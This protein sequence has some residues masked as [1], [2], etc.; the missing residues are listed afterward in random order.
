LRKKWE[1]RG[2]VLPWKFTSR[3]ENKS[4]RG[5]SLLGTGFREGEILCAILTRHSRKK[6]RRKEGLSSADC[7]TGKRGSNSPDTWC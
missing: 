2:R 5:L 6:K 3:M 4:C 1:E 7:F